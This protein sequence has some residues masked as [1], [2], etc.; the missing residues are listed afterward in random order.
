M[1][2]LLSIT[3]NILSIDTQ[4]YINASILNLQYQQGH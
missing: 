3:E 4:Q 2:K 1:L